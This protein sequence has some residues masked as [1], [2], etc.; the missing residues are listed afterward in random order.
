M[1]EQ[2]CG[3]DS[4]MD[5]SEAHKVWIVKKKTGQRRDNALTMFGLE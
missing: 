5:K 1:P 2:L 3:D 4:G